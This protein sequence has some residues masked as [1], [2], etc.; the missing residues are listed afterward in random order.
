MNAWA[1]LGFSGVWT[2]LHNDLANSQNPYGG[3]SQ[4]EHSAHMEQ[5]LAA[6]G[7]HRPSNPYQNIYPFPAP[8]PTPEQLQRQWERDFMRDQEEA[9]AAELRQA[10]LRTRIAA[11]ILAGLAL[12]FLFECALAYF[13][14]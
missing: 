7:E 12:A 3:V 4:Q 11:Y 2:N 13:G 6:Y 14:A 9:F 10:R 5:L 1:I 8:P